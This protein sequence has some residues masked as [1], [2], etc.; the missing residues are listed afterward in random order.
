MTQGRRKGIP[1]NHEVWF[2][3]PGRCSYVHAERDRQTDIE[4]ERDRCPVGLC[5][6]RHPR[7]TVKFT[8][9][10]KVWSSQKGLKLSENRNDR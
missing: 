5:L 9:H 3:Y 6:C 7:G 1:Q 8:V 4:R 2:A 10:P